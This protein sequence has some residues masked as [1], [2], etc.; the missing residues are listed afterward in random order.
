M[1]FSCLL[2]NKE[3]FFFF[4]FFWHSHP[5]VF[6]GLPLQ[7]PPSF[8]VI[9]P[10]TCI[11]WGWASL[12]LHVHKMKRSMSLHKCLNVQISVWD[13]QVLTATCYDCRQGGTRF[14][15][16][17]ATVWWPVCQKWSLLIISLLQASSSSGGD[18]SCIFDSQASDTIIFWKWDKSISVFIPKEMFDAFSSRYGHCPDYVSNMSPVA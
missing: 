9:I 11:S 13:S 12:G 7:F 5:N 10:D 16:Q 15:Y 4:L 1:Y 17:M 6:R 2:N 18:Q 14:S 3:F 8:A